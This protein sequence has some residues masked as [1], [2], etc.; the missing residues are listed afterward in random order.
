MITCCIAQGTLPILC[1]GLHG[2]RI[3]K[4]KKNRKVDIC[5]C[6]IDSLCCTSETNA[7][8]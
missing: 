6:I 5:V 1:N 3:L 7:T 8:V 4:K 2:K